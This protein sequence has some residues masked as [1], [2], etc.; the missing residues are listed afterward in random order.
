MA[1][2]PSPLTYLQAVAHGD[3]TGKSVF[4]KIGYT[5]TCNATESDVWSNAGVFSFMSAAA[6]LEVVSSDNT[7]D[8]GNSNKSGTSTGGS[9]TTL[10]DSGATFTSATAVAIGDCVLLDKSGTTPEW[11]YVTSVDS[12]TQLTISNGFSSGGTG[13]GRA[14]VVISRAAKTG[15]MAIKIDYLT[16]AYAQKYEIVILNGTSAVA[17]INTDIFRINSFR[18]IASGSTNVSKGSLTIRGLS[19]GTTYSFITAGYTRARNSA[20]TVPA[21]K[22]L[23]ATSLNAGAV[24]ATGTQYARIYLRANIEPYTMLLTNS[25]FY[26]FGETMAANSSEELKF[27]LPI[28]FP[29]KTDIKVSCI[30]TAST[31]INTVLRGWLE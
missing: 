29:A 18:M 7:Q 10:I 16:S 15:A 4:T 24:Y 1:Y 17:T 21:G 12:A 2:I 28:K 3:V 31:A 6:G 5:P 9:V 19:A 30:G 20:Y 26:P 13:S 11:G 23:Y 25:I 8:V 27:D 14:Y 22:T